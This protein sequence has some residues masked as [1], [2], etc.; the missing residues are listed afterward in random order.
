M[1]NSMEMFTFSVFDWK[2]LFCAILVV[3]VKIVSLSLS[4]GLSWNTFFEE[5]WSIKSEFPVQAKIS[6]IL[7]ASA[8]IREREGSISPFSIYGQL[9]NS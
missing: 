4:L 3:K 6:Y 9:P 8:K 7:I 2:Y 5:I 1:Q